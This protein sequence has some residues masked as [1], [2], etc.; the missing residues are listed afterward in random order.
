MSLSA[1]AVTRIFEGRYDWSSARVMVK[2][3]AAHA[4]ALLA[5]LNIQQ[6]HFFTK[7]AVVVNHQFARLRVQQQMAGHA[8]V[9]LVPQWR[10]A[11]VVLQAPG[12]QYLV[13]RI[14]AHHD[15][16]LHID[17][18]RIGDAAPAQAAYF[19]GG[20]VLRIA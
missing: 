7:T 6:H 13:G 15:V 10:Q 8:K 19:N 12:A 5:G 11:L 17:Q 14:K 20:V 1:D 3:A 18:R 9:G 2:A 16:P 4:G